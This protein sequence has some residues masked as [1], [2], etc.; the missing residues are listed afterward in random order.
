MNRNYRQILAEQKAEIPAILATGWVKREQEDIIKINSRLVQIITGIRRS[1]KSTLSH[2]LLSG[3]RYAY[4]NFD[5]ERLVNIDASE[6]N[7]ILEAVYSV[8]GDFTHLLLDEIQNVDS[9]H[10]FV[11][12]L[13]RNNI[14]VILTGSNSRL[15]TRESASSLTGRYSIINLFTFSFTEF[16]RMKGI[17]PVWNDT[18]REKGILM[19]LFDEYLATG[20]F[21]EVHT[22]EDQK[23][24]LS[25]LFE[26]IVTRDIIYRYK[27]RNIRS[28]KDLA[29][30]LADKFSGE[31]SFNR[32]KNIL[33]LGSENTVKN[34]ISYFEEAWLFLTLPKFSFKKQENLRFRKIYNIDTGFSGISVNEKISDYGRNIENIV[35][36]QLLR[37]SG[38]MNYELFYFKKNYEVDFVIYKNRKITELI[39]VAS[40]VHDPK[41]FKREIRSLTS[42]ADDLNA[43]KLTLLTLEDDEDIQINSR[44]IEIRN[45]VKWLLLTDGVK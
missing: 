40:S 43:A 33:A 20:G 29:I 21:P 37:H 12:R 38:R 18:A 9:W 13:L 8:Y 35:F 31:I 45:L 28:V 25:N 24:Y 26:A 19:K 3:T 11:N 2:R 22:G 32:L 27:I 30:I 42:A 4:V 41:T 36:L 5:D 10:L 17:N 44:K 16:L 7:T 1:G 23:T 14:H 39:Q 15:L 34:Y 6:L